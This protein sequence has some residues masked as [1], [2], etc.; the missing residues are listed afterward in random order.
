[1]TSQRHKSVFSV[2]ETKDLIN[3]HSKNEHGINP[4]STSTPHHQCPVGHKRPGPVRRLAPSYIPGDRIRRFPQSSL[5]LLPTRSSGEHLNIQFHSFLNLDHGGYLL[6]SQAFVF[7]RVGWGWIC[8]FF[9]VCFICSG[10]GRW[11]TRRVMSEE[12]VASPETAL[13]KENT[14][15]RPGRLFQ[16]QSVSQQL[17]R[18]LWSTRCCCESCTAHR[19]L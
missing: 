1:M 4:P 14:T 8:L 16:H 19:L 3:P 17:L 9:Y 12:P 5:K 7:Q 13:K 6:L 18:D 10:S 2:C 11:S 15:I